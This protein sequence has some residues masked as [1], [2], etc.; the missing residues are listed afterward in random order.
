MVF[1]ASGSMISMRPVLIIPT[2][3]GDLELGQDQPLAARQILSPSIT[4]STSHCWVG[5]R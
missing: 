3:L 1:P 2:F 4:D 5:D